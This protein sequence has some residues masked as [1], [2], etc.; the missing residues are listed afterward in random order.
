MLDRS[1]NMAAFLV[2][3]VCFI[4]T[5]FLDDMI[6]GICLPCSYSGSCKSAKSSCSCHLDGG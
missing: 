5:T 2:T 4:L 1:S 6:L 3:L